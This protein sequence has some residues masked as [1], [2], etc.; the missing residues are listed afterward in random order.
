MADNIHDYTP[1]YAVSSHTSSGR[2]GG[3]IKPVAPRRGWKIKTTKLT[4]FRDSPK[5]I[6]IYKH[7]L[8]YF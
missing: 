2:A 7:P 4:L 5:T 6:K 3:L 1:V 8:P